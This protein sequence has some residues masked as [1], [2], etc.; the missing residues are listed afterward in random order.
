MV[1]GNVLGSSEGLVHELG[2][3]EGLAVGRIVRRMR[4][5]VE[6]QC[7]IVLVLLLALYL[8]PRTVLDCD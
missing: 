2:S 1:G 3:E 5:P 6:N 8:G 7:H 4:I